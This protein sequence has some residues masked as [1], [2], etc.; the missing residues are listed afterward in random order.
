MTSK[1]KINS[2]GSQET[3]ST[4]ECPPPSL[5]DH[6]KALNRTALFLR[7]YEVRRQPIP[8]E[9]TAQLAALE[10][11]GDPE[12]SAGLEMLNERMFA[13]MIQ[14]LQDTAGSQKGS[15]SQE[16]ASTPREV[17]QDLLSW[18]IQKN[19]YFALWVNYKQFAVCGNPAEPWEQFVHSHVQ[20][21]SGFEEEFTLLMGQMG[22]L[23]TWFRDQNRP[24]PK[25]LFERAWFL[26]Y[27]GEAE[28]SW[29]ARALI[30]ELM[31]C[32]HTCA[33]A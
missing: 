13:H 2:L 6:T 20:S 4:G 11:L 15:N 3:A 30:H 24:L 5:R 25:L 7:F 21:P 26:H 19:R 17:V 16:C 23:L 27:L 10:K 28:R 33:S 31:E 1:I 9:F 8:P 14:F 22:E 29:Q 12:R 18:L 32:T